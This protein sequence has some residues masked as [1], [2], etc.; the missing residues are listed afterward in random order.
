MN[1]FKRNAAGED[2]ETL[3]GFILRNTD[4][5]GRYNGLMLPNTRPISEDPLMFWSPGG[6]EGLIPAGRKGE[7]PKQEKEIRILL[8]S[9]LTNPDRRLDLYT[10]ALEYNVISYCEPLIESLV[11]GV[12]DTA[13]ELLSLAVWLISESFDSEPMKLGISLLTLFKVDQISINNGTSL[14][15][16]LLAIGK[17]PE[18]SYYVLWV[19][20][21][22]NYS[23]RL[24]FELAKYTTGWGKLFTVVALEP[25]TEEIREWLLI[26][27][28]DDIEHPLELSTGIAE[29]SDIGFFLK[30]QMIPYNMY[31]AAT[32]LLGFI[33]AKRDLDS[34]DN[35]Q[36][37]LLDYFRLSCEHCSDLYELMHIIRLR[38]Y[39]LDKENRIFWNDEM[40]GD[41]MESIEIIEK[42]KNWDELIWQELCADSRAKI[43]C[44]KWL[45]QYKGFDIYDTIMEELE[46]NPLK[47]D[48]YS[49]LFMTEDMQRL[50]KVLEIAEKNIDIY[51]QTDD[52]TATIV[53]EGLKTHP[54]MGQ[55]IIEKMLRSEGHLHIA[56]A[57]DVIEAWG[58]DYVPI[59][60][61]ESLIEALTITRN[62]RNQQRIQKLLNTTEK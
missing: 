14:Q 15:D 2:A 40:L 57:L 4:D 33:E 50:G 52:Y 13:S 36:G 9:A 12:E 25:E 1:W 6:K 56:T 49:E 27:G 35:I 16:I 41:M 18:F 55:I 26:H 22:N 7:N 37:I 53:T 30:Q 51:M 5:D 17:C 59:C 23:N 32:K 10:K 61:Q 43:Y 38:D 46:K 31:R 60:I 47:I 21:A 24:I 39:A 28:L 3:L 54:Y 45:A 8:N 62:D 11:D 29:K 19:F 44:A 42:K 48:I 58:T 34:L 20:R